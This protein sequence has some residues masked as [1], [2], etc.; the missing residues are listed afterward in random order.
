MPDPVLGIFCRYNLFYP[1][2]SLTKR[3]SCLLLLLSRVRLWPHGLQHTRLP[4]PLA[5]PGDCSNSCPLSCWCH[6]T[7]LILCGP[8][9]MPSSF[10]SVRVFSNESA[11]HIRWPKDWS[12]SI[13]PSS[14]YS[15]LVFFRIDWLDLLALQGILKS[16][17]AP[18]FKSIN[19]LA[20]SLLCDPTLTSIRDYWRNN[21]F[22]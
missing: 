8:L 6:P 18:Q 10:P 13:H 11:L 22:D 19:S 14:E 7:I 1:Y 17:P 16:S 21:S 20:V 2:K 12:F 5:T 15:G 3:G 4:C 9:L